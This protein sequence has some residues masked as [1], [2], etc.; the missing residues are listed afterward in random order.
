[1]KAK[2]AA[3][4]DHDGKLPLA[5]RLA[6]AKH[7]QLQAIGLRSY[8][9]K[10]LIEMDDRD[11][12][13]VYQLFKKSDINLAYLDGNIGDYDLNSDSQYKEQLEEFK[14]LIALSDRLK[15]NV[16]CLRLPRFTKVID[17]FENI[18]IRLTPF[19]DAAMR[20]RKRIWI[21]PSNDYKANTYAYVIKKMKAQHIDVYF[22][23][24]HFLN[25]KQ[26]NTTAYRLLKRY[27]G[28][29]ACHDQ[30]QHGNP[31]LLGYG[32][33][34]VIG[35]FKRLIRDRYNGLLIVDNQFFHQVFS[36]AK[37]KKG[38]FGFRHRKQ[39]KQK[40]TLQK[41]I[42][43]VLFPNEQTRVCTYDDVLSNQIRLVRA[44]FS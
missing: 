3:Y 35:L 40:E 24:I 41:E 11:I 39:Q 14:F 16:V 6:L 1:M 25:I 29:F 37:T 15:T 4:F 28:A 27:I 5:D 2:L 9:G 10:P 38:L 33:T 31:R 18:K 8:Q 13:E 17:E 21:L 32:K 12:K 34:D 36:E 44:L 22:D 26:S 42:S 7:H 43:H 23:P 20:R 30:D 19:F